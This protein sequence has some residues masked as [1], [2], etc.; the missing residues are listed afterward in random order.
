VAPDPGEVFDACADAPA[1]SK[2]TQPTAKTASESGLLARF[3]KISF[4]RLP[5]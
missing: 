2:Q 1:G 5:S 3:S 4:V